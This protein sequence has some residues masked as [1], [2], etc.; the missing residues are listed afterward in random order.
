[1]NDLQIRYFLKA[2]QRL[3]FSQA[4]KELFISQPALSQQISAIETEL[5]MQLFI[6]DKNK[7]R[8]TPA[9]TVLLQELP[10]CSR[11]FQETLAKARVV[12]QGHSGVLRLGVLEGQ[13]LSPNF[14]KA[15]AAFSQAYPNL[16]IQFSTGSFSTLRR[17]LDIGELDVAFTTSF[18]V[19]VS[20]VYLWVKTD[21]D[22]CAFL[23][24][25]DYSTAAKT[26]RGWKDLKEETLILVDTEDSATVRELVLADC[27]RAGFVPRLLPAP[28]SADE[29]LWI[30]AGLGV[31]ISNTDAYICLNPNVRCLKS[32]PIPGIYFVLAWH[33]EN[34][35]SSIA[36]FT[37]FVSDYIQTQGLLD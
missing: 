11:L 14:R 19:A 34:T 29:A 5:N 24:S 22:R 6:R 36:L 37:N 16:H 25:R 27:R 21:Y 35:N 4:A 26:V 31:G 1:M 15:Y 8:L 30:D 10:E 20:P 28:S 9:A 12:S 32:F 23:A 33:R 18:D 13:V 2:A 17:Q 7:L 3:N